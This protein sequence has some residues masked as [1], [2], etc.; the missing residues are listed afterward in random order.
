MAEDL[1]QSH[2]IIARIGK[3]LMRHRVPEQVGMQ[4]DAGDG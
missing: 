1:G 2:K 4:A 3:I